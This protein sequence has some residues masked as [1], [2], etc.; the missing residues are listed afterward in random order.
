MARYG[1]I[2]MVYNSTPDSLDQV[3]SILE[4]Y[5][6]DFA[7][8]ENTFFIETTSKA[9][10]ADVIEDLSSLPIEFTFFHNHISDG[11]S[12]KSKGLD[13]EFTDHANK[14]LFE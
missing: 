12:L 11:S 10:T 7:T 6:I 5:H 8:K 1:N 2:L 9:N 14:I 13:E 4:K 3:I